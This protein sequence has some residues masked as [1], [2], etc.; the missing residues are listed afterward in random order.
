MTQPELEISQSEEKY[1]KESLF[2]QH[3]KFKHKSTK[4]NEIK[5]S[6]F[7]QEGMLDMNLV[8]L[9]EVFIIF[10]FILFYFFYFIFIY[11]LLIYQQ[12]S[13]KQD[14]SERAYNYCEFVQFERLLQGILD[15]A[16]RQKLYSLGSKIG[17]LMV[18][19]PLIN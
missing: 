14:K 6:L 18:T 19:L 7:K 8:S 3:E 17:E 12:L 15:Y 5:Q 1:L 13:M 11:F 2:L 9:V 10:I 16:N 4:N